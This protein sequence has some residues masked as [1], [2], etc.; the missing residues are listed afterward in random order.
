MKIFL[1]Q[2]VG[3]NQKNFIYINS[4]QMPPTHMSR[5]FN[6]KLETLEEAR[7]NI[8]QL[9]LNIIDILFRKFMRLNSSR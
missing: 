6:P 5:T 4:D 9:K 3:I 8:E 2:R 7:K 1:D